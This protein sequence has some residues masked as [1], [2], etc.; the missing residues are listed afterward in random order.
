MY[1]IIK[2]ECKALSFAFT[3]SLKA[4]FTDSGAIL[5]LLLAAML[6]PVVY[7]IAYSEEVLTE[8]PV[9]MVDNDNTAT[10]R[11]WVKMMD[12]TPQ[13]NIIK[14]TAEMASAEQL[15]WEGEVKAILKVPSGF[16]KK[17]F[18]SEQASISMYADASNFLFYKETLKSTMQATGTLSAAIEFKRQLAK[19]AR[20]EQAMDRIQPIQTQV[21]NL[22][23]PSGSYGSFVMPGI[24]LIIIQQTL[25][26][27]IGL[28][29]GAGRERKRDLTKTLGFDLKKHAF[30]TILGKSLAYFLIGVFNLLFA[31]VLVYHWFSFPTKGEFFN[32]IVLSIPYLFS[33]IFMGMAISLGF[34]HREYSIMFL[35][36]LTPIVLFITGLSWP[37]EAMPELL[38]SVFKLVP[39]THMVPAYIR[40]RT[41]GV[42][43]SEIKPELSALSI[44]M[45]LYF[46][47]AVVGFKI[48]M[49]KKPDSV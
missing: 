30:A 28:V 25:L 42:S 32:V 34:K 8:L 41:M 20:P 11:Q 37:I 48:A 35:V 7:S 19:G 23:N 39:S 24:M 6:Y 47:L 16:E 45:L 17:I 12:A 40:L 31:M 36:F 33:I 1:D 13:L 10:S 4:I 44:Q 43:L 18:K 14:Q 26:I 21:Y 22:Y 3:D 46:F 29:G 38:H 9:V 2:T 49:K 5:I 27:G 15:F